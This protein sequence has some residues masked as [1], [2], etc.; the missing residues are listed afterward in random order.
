MPETVDEKPPTVNEVVLDS[1]DAVEEAFSY[2]DKKYNRGR[3]SRCSG[4]MVK[5]TSRS[6][7]SEH[8]VELRDAP[9]LLIENVYA[10][11]D[12][13]QVMEVSER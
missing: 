5:L 6:R 11:D 2:L 9:D 3:I 8:F 4:S 12:G 13:R 10:T 1:L 7:H